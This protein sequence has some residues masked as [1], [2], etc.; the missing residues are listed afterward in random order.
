MQTAPWEKIR[1]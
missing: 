1:S